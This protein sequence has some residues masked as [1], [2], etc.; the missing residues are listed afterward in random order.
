MVMV[1]RTTHSLVLLSAFSIAVPMEGW[2]FRHVMVS[3]YGT[4]I[5]DVLFSGEMCCA[6][7]VTSISERP[8]AY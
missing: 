5:R 6:V 8:T 4:C 7:A 2:F 1:V 3:T